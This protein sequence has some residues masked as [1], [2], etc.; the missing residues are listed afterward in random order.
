[1]TKPSIEVVNTREY[2]YPQTASKRSRLLDID[3]GAIQPGFSIKFRHNNPAE[4]QRIY[5]SVRGRT[6]SRTRYHHETWSSTK[7]DNKTVV[8]SRLS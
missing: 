7:I 3:L 1:M 8:V 2:F 5:D 4:L 6:S